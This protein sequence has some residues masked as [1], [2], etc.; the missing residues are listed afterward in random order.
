MDLTEQ[1]ARALA[2][3]EHGEGAWEHLIA[4]QLSRYLALAQAVLPFIAAERER[5]AV[6]ADKVASDFRR[7]SDK[8]EA[9]LNSTHQFTGQMLLLGVGAAERIAAAIRSQ[10]P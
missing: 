1:I 3:V 5:C 4:M 7:G 6:I 2:E 9:S 10:Q 8:A